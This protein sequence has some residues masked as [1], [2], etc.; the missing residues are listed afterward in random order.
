[1]G[2]V[3]RFS[4]KIFCPITVPKVSLG[5]SFIVA[6]FSGIKKVWLRVGGESKFSIE[7]FLGHSAGNFRRGVLYCCNNFAYRKSSDKRGGGK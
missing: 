2:R 7:N 3:S 4:S 5:E 6:L 1:M